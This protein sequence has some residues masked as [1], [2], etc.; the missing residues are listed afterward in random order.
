MKFKQNLLLAT[1]AI[2]LLVSANSH[3]GRQG[4]N[5]YYGAG[6]GIGFLKT[7]DPLPTGEIMF[8]VEED[9]WALE[10][11]GFSSIE[12][13]TDDSAVNASINGSHLGIAYR[14]IERHRMWFKIKV[15]NTR[16]KIDYTDISDSGSSSGTGYAIGIGM[17]MSRE[18]RLEI[19]YNF[20]DNSDIL[21][22]LHMISAHY[23][24]GGSEY[25][26]KAF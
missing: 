12:M 3:A 20:Y 9:G 4:I 14:T 16:L 19:D 10:A 26:G 18:A 23:F 24:W 22:P 15:S 7:I 2:A 21:D 5:F 11:I 25:Q 6:T 17:R 8:G 1:A 13:G